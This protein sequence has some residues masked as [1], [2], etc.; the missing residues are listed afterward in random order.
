MLSQRTTRSRAVLRALAFTCVTAVIVTASLL[1]SVAAEG[2]QTTASDPV[3]AALAD[4]ARQTEVQQLPG[5][6]W[7][8]PFRATEIGAAL[9]L[10][11][12]TSE[13]VVSIP[14]I[15][16][17]VPLSIRT[18]LTVSPDV[19]GGYLEYQGPGVPSRLIDFAQY[20]GKPNDTPIELDLRGM[21]ATNGSLKLTLRTRLR[22]NDPS[23]VTSLLGAWAELRNGGIVLSG[24]E[25]PPTSVST[26]LPRLL[27]R[28]EVYL[29]PTPTPAEASAGLRV[30]QAAQRQAIGHNPEVVVLPLPS[31][32]VPDVGYSS[33][34]RQVL[35]SDQLPSGASLEQTPAGGTVLAIGGDDAALDRTTR[36]LSS[37]YSDLAVGSTLSVQRFDP[38]GAEGLVPDGLPAPDP[39]LPG[40][41]TTTTPTGTGLRTTRFTLDQLQLGTER[42]TG[43][44]RLELPVAVSQTTLGGP[45][46]SV[47][48]HLE[49]ALTPIADGA[50]ATLSLLVD[51]QLIASRNL[52]GFTGEKNAD[53]VLT[54]GRFTLDGKVADESVK[55]GLD[56]RVIVD[57]SPP[58]GEC[59]PGDIPFMMQLDP[60]ASTLTVDPG[61]T[62][63]PGFERFPQTLAPAG[64]DIGL[65][66]YG[67]ERVNLAFGLVLAMQR[68]TSKLL[69]GTFTD[70]DSAIG[71]TA[72]A[73]LV[74]QW[75]PDV[76]R[77]AALLSSDPLSY[78]DD[79]RVERLQ[80]TIDQPR[81][82]L[83]AFKS[84]NKDRMLLTWSDGNGAPGSGLAQAEDL[85]AGISTRTTDFSALFGDT[86]IISPGTP[87]LS[88]SLRGDRIQATPV[89]QG[90]DY[91]ARAKPLVLAVLVLGAI[92]LGMAWVIR[93]RRRRAR[94]DG[95]LP[96]HSHRP[97]P[98]APTSPARSAAPTEASRPEGPG[99]EPDDA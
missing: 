13:T 7:L 43:L 28:L 67:T 29:P 37:S 23:C 16:G 24:Q 69:D 75:T 74:S 11:G 82:I 3:A 39:A 17:T 31:G 60:R 81:A 2:A 86:Y 15:D 52:T 27:Q 33:G 72:P 71:S 49:G 61:Q 65:D 91:I 59:K 50:D 73:L 1:P 6:L 30:A 34:T 54:P 9:R 94:P 76:L 47:D 57:Y 46:R 84:A 55:R 62:L 19:D 77:S 93:R 63:P 40:S 4:P 48:V 41:T 21:Q 80:L 22:S 64:F 99:S 58:G 12:E 51:N 56:V 96:D 79:Q 38:T 35:V 98:P 26:Y 45:V 20:G 88:I 85:V 70:L 68:T 66:Q 87:P 97:D 18:Q 78:T 25:L 95:G 10:S 8:V 89:R 36:L 5:D 92:V 83:E 90:P 53:G 14:I 32:T 44:G 42:V